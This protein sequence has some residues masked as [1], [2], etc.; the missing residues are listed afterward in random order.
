MTGWRRLKLTT[1]GIGKDAVKVFVSGYSAKAL[2][3][4]VFE[5]WGQERAK[6]NATILQNDRLVLRGAVRGTASATAILGNQDL[7][8][9]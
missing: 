3:D 5:Y 2:G 7:S 8:R 6:A 4:N 1:S 9:R